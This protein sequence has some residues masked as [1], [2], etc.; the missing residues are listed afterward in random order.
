MTPGARRPGAHAC[1][2]SASTVSPCALPR[3]RGTSDPE[4]VEAAREAGE[5]SSWRV[6]SRSAERGR[7]RAPGAR[8][9]RWSARHA[10]TST[11]ATGRR[12]PSRSARRRRASAAGS[13]P[14]RRRG[15]HHRVTPASRTAAG[16]DGRRRTGSRRRRSPGRSRSPVVG[17][18]RRMPAVRTRPRPPAGPR[19]TAGGAPRGAGRMAAWNRSEG[20]LPWHVPSH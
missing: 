3:N 5:G 9:S 18:A 1:S 19:K 8:T 12:T 17:R 20:D 11:V 6:R 14:G 2:R 13:E 10:A 4:R 7:R 16:R 15:G